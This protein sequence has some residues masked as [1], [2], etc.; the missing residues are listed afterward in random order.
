MTQAAIIMMSVSVGTILL[1]LL[2][3]LA[4]V[5]LSPMVEDAED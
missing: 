5:M 3:C 2:F 1:L 4:K